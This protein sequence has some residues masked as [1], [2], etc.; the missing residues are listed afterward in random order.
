MPEFLHL[1][2][3]SEALDR[4]LNAIPESTRTAPELIPAVEALN[5]FLCEPVTAPH[6]LPPFT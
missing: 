1:L 3:S 5:R 2:S 4:F 6:P